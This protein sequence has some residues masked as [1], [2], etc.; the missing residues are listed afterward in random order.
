LPIIVRQSI[1]RLLVDFLQQ[2]QQRLA[3]GIRQVQPHGPAA[4]RPNDALP[5]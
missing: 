2:L 1:N 5:D 3:L 4:R